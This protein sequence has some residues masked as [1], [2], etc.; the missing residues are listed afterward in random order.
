[1]VECRYRSTGTGTQP[2]RDNTNADADV[3]IFDFFCLF[4]AQA[5]TDIFFA[6]IAITLSIHTRR[7]LF[8]KEDDKKR[9]IDNTKHS[10]NTRLYLNEKL[11]TDYIKFE[12]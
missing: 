3:R 9:R 5:L 7:K 11:L 2:F 10:P 6:S 4:C 8:L 12:K 1:M